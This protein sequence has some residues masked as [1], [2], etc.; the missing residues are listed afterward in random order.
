[1]YV[2]SREKKNS[3]FSLQKEL[4]FCNILVRDLRRP[5]Q[6]KKEIKGFENLDVLSKLLGFPVWM[7]FLKVLMF[8]DFKNFNDC[9]L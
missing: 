8:F 4:N 6:E 1:M 5:K 7:R 3:F 2:A 9:K